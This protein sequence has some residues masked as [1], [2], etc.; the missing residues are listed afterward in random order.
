MTDPSLTVKARYPKVRALVSRKDITIANLQTKV[1]LKF[2]TFSEKKPEHLP[3]FDLYVLFVRTVQNALNLQ[4]LHPVPAR[5][6]IGPGN[7]NLLVRSVM[8][9][10]GWVH[11][12]ENKKEANVVWTQA[13][14]KY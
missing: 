5:V 4:V 9:T 11:L 14:K 8:R 10:R 7:N 3:P 1:K 12:T 6:Y 2:R 13:F